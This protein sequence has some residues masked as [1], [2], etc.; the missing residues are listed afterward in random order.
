MDT[1]LLQNYSEA[2]KAA[3]LSAIASLA[4]ADRQASEA[5][6]QFLHALAQ[7]AGL[8]E[9]AAQ[10]VLAAAHDPSTKAFSSTSTY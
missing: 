10:Q 3:Y 8:S 4:T 6:T 9:G 7:Q 5:E 2:E 1:Q